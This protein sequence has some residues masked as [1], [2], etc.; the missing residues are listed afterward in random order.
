MKLEKAI[1]LV[2][3]CFRDEEI[4]RLYVAGDKL[5][6][7]QTKHDIEHAR[8]VTEMAQHVV[9]E[10]EELKPGSI[11]AWT[12]SVV[13]PLAAF[14]HDIG[15]AVNVDQHAKAGAKWAQEYLSR[16]TLPG[17]NE[18]LP[19][20]VVKR[21]CRIVACHRSETFLKME[22][23]DAA[24]AIVV[25][26]DKCV[27]DE[28]RVRPLR[29]AVL[30]ALQVVRATWIP[31]RKGWVH[32]RVHFAIKHAELVVGKPD[33]ILDIDFDS[34]VCKPSLFYSLYIKR[35][36]SCVR[37]CEFLG[38]G[39]KLKF[40]EVAGEGSQLFAYSPTMTTFVAENAG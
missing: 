6:S 3:A 17:D 15:R 27:G 5:S 7:N 37:A 2:S 14:L 32:D 1:L 29:A 21:I 13:I 16:L 10:L 9:A 24:L 35:F 31:F 4:E 8:L 26:A 18:T 38:F 23:N 22:L 33:M 30:R 12:K 34:R 28:E 40:N 11:D 39:F 19:P 36:Q 25:L 20:D